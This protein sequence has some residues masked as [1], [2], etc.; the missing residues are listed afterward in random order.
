[1]KDFSLTSLFKPSL[2]YEKG[3]KFLVSSLETKSPTPSSK[4]LLI[5][6]LINTYLP[7][8]ESPNSFTEHSPSSLIILTNGPHYSLHVSYP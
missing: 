6:L 2:S 1:M 5:T 7:P 3:T 4:T 8:V